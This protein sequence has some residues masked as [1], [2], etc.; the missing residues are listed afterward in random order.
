M[1]ETP[2]TRTIGLRTIAIFEACKGLLV[3]TVGFGLTYLVN[4]DW[5]ALVENLILRIEL[6]PEHSYSRISR[7]FLRAAAHWTHGQI[8]GLA[9]LAGVYSLLRFIEAMGLWQEKAWAEW[10]GV[11]SGGIYL[12][13]EI[14]ELIHD[15]SAIKF[16]IFVTNLLV[17]AYLLHV[18]LAAPQDELD[19]M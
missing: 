1:Q 10:L 11:I 15:V 5:Q 8:L 9:A 17:V 12:P 2:L 4:R 14:F 6:G 16:G 3:L 13:I 18:R 19:Q 7:I